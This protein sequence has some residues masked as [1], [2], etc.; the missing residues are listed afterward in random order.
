MS[1]LLIAA[2]ALLINVSAPALLTAKAPTV[3]IAITDADQTTSVEIIDSS[4]R[5]FHIWS[6]PGVRVNG[7]PE[8]EG[9]VADWS[10]GNVAEPPKDLR[11]YRVAFYTACD[12]REAASC[13]TSEPQL[14]YVVMYAYSPAA[15]R[16]YVY[17]PGRGE[18]WY[19]LNTQSI[20]RGVEGNWFLAS[21]QWQRFVTRLICPTR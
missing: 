12:S 4:V 8:M 19:D 3:K 2:L 21:T 18:Q 1:R 16:G 7:V 20:A 10:K 5:Q 6:G 13:R 17:V 14:S 9:F 11:R 15:D